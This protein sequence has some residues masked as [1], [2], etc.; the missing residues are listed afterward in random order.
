MFNRGTL[1]VLKRLLVTALGA[2]G[3]GALATGPVFAQDQ[4]PGPRLYGDISSCAGGMLSAASTGRG[5]MSLLGTGG[6]LDM[7]FDSDQTAMGI[8]M[9]YTQ[10]EALIVTNA[11]QSGLAGVTTGIENAD[12]VAL[13]DLAGCDNPVANNVSDASELYSTYV[14]AK[15]TFEALE[16]PT[17]E[18]TAT[19]N[20]AR[21]NKNAFAGD[22]Y[23]SVF[24]RAA[25]LTAANRAIIDYNKLVGSDGTLATLKTNGANPGGYDDISVLGQG[26]IFAADNTAVD[27]S[28]IIDGDDADDNANNELN[29]AV[30][31][32]FGS[33]NTAGYRAIAGNNTEDDTN[34]ASTLSTGAA[35]NDAGALQ[36]DVANAGSNAVSRAST[37]I[38]TLG[39]IVHELGRWETAVSTADAA[40]EA[41][42]DAGNLDT[43][44]QEEAL[45]RAKLARDHV[46][47]ELDRLT[48]VVRSQNLEIVDTSQ[49]TIAGS[50][51]NTTDDDVVYE[52][53]RDLLDAYQKSRTS[54]VTAAGRVRSAIS[55]L[56]SAN[57]ALQGKLKDPNSY[58]S[59]LVTLREYQEAEARSELEDAGGDDALQSFKDAVTA[60][61]N[62]VTSAKAQQ[63]AHQHLT[64]DPTSTTS[65]LLEALLA[66]EDPQTDAF[67][68]DDGQAL[69]NAISAV[70]S[71]VSTLEGNLTDADGNPIDLSNLDSG[72]NALTAGADTPDDATDDGVIT[73]NARNI[74]ANTDDISGIKTDLYGTTESQHGD[75]AACA[76]GA[77]GLLNLATCNEARSVHNE[78]TLVD[79]D[80]KLQAKKAY[81]EAIQGELLVDN[82]GNGTGEGGMSRLDDIEG[83]LALKAQYI[84][85]LAAEVGIDEATGDGMVELADGTMGSRIDKNA[86]DIAAE[87]SAR[88]M[89]DTALGE[90]IDAEASAREMAD[91]ALGGRIDAEASARE[92]ADTALGG[93][94]DDEASAREMADTALGGRI[95]AEAS[96]REMADTALGGR[97][98]DEASAREMADTALG[99]RI[100][101]EATARMGADMMLATAI[102]DEATARMG[103]DMMLS[104]AIA[105]EASARASADMTLAT[106]IDGNTTAIAQEAS[107]RMSADMMLASA[108]DEE[109]A[110][111]VS[112]DMALDS[113]VGSNAG[114]IAANMNAIGSNAS[115]ISDNRNMIGELSD[116]LDVVRAGVAASMALAGM[117]AINGRGISIGVGSFDGE[118]AFAVG[119]QIQGEQASFKVGITSGGGA[120][121]AS[122]GVGFNF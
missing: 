99:G 88:E 29:A 69:L 95:D 64:S 56:D 18:D 61:S 12:L 25:K 102:D 81:I 42:K 44:T 55:S 97:I 7:A 60:A 28:A 105:E 11:A 32:V 26:R 17:A 46:Q 82:E 6:V 87:S 1:M 79:H 27:L 10:N 3:L 116:D 41:A 20:T 115:A 4:I 77:G 54:V 101:D 76:E 111:R 89:A 22:V 86:E 13:L 14:S 5:A 40:L 104:T 117:P 92:M 72:V 53:E 80:T 35:F 100:D 108:L 71:K 94:I 107:D 75:T 122:A 66:S 96:A 113:R 65:Q 16:E 43:R 24:D 93:R 2:L 114:A 109:A 38:N 39:E 30:A 62:A 118:S 57:K 37:A 90:R 103:A 48:R 36:F 110:A 23:N 112:A 78:A 15:R 9:D 63:T 51:P 49:V 98:D 119:F 58:L 74:A 34:A 52:N 85:T 91:T 67:E 8:Q 33:G 50:D 120:T 106:A 68:D 59:Q 73:T 31:P 45:R 84:G 83:K 121:G 70:D 21:D 19:Y 47:G